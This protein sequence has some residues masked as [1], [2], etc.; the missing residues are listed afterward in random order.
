MILTVPTVFAVTL[1]SDVTVATAVSEDLKDLEP[2]AP[3]MET[4]VVF[5]TA[6]EDAAAFTVIEQAALLILKD[7]VFLEA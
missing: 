5:P 6:T 7:T 3:V 2:F 1:P 4:V